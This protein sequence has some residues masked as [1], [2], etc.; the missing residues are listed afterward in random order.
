MKILTPQRLLFVLV[1]SGMGFAVVGLN[2]SCAYLTQG[3]TQA[4]RPAQQ[5]NAPV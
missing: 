3:E 5:V 1:L 4:K 2:S